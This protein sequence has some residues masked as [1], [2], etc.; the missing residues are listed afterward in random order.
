MNITL[1]KMIGRLKSSSK[2]QVGVTA[3][4]YAMCQP[5]FTKWGMSEEMFTNGFLALLALLG[6]QAAADFGKEKI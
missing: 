2:W 4:I 6:A 1:P 3:F 5:W